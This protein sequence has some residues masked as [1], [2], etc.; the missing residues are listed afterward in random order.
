MFSN[1][2]GIS[3]WAILNRPFGTGSCFQI[4]PGFHPAILNRPFGTGSCFQTYPGFHPGLLS[5]APS[6]LNHV[7]KPTRDF[8]LGYS[9]PSLWDWIMLSNLP[10]I[11]SCYSQ[12]SLRDWIMFSNLPRISSWATLNRLFGIESCFQTYPGFHP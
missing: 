6:G 8:I 3:S 9:Q 11:S 7:F 12:P 1:L 10:R 2:P 5:T 4:Y